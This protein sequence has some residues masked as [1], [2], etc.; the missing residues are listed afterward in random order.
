[1]LRRVYLPRRIAAGTSDSRLFISTTSAASIAISVP[2]PI[3]IPIS[4]RAKAGASFIPSPT[5]AVFE[6][7]DSFLTT[8]SL[9]SGSTPAMTSSIPACF[10]IA[11]AVRSLSPVSMTTLR[12]I[13]LS[14]ATASWLSGFIVSATA[15]RPIN[16][17]SS[18]KNIG[19]LPSADRLSAA[20]LTSSPTA[21]F[22]AAK[23]RFPPIILLPSI[24]P[25]SP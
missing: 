12:P 3:A 17:P 22:S 7:S 9:P 1:M 6:S 19:V 16:F 25:F 14:S 15:I 23:E 5:I 20:A 8:A 10:A 21:A 4:A 11:L 18:T 13:P 2:A 24:T